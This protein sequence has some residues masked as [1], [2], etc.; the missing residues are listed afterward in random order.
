MRRLCDAYHKPE[1]HWGRR[2]RVWHSSRFF[3]GRQKIFSCRLVCGGPR[4]FF[5]A[6]AYLSQWGIVMRVT[7]TSVFSNLASFFNFRRTGA[8][9]IWMTRPQAKARLVATKNRLKCGKIL[10]RVDID[11]K[12]AVPRQKIC[13][14]AT[15]NRL[16]CGSPQSPVLDISSIHSII[17]TRV[18]LVACN[19]ELVGFSSRLSHC[20]RSLLVLCGLLFSSTLMTLC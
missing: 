18:M 9:L 7:W 4:Q 19:A 3:G 15:K 11:K 12:S 20:V 5:G 2:L 17:D 8:I 6:R 1:S 13:S 10:T 16:V 14:S